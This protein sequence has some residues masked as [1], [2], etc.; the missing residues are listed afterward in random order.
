MTHGLLDC[1]LATLPQVSENED[2]EWNYEVYDADRKIFKIVALRVYEGDWD[3]REKLLEKIL[4][5]PPQAHHYISSFL[6]S[7][8]ILS[9]RSDPPE[10]KRLLLVWKEIGNQLMS[11]KTFTEFK[12]RGVRE[13]WGD[14]LFYGSSSQGIHEECF[15]PFVCGLSEFYEY[16]LRSLGQSSHSH[17]KLASIFSSKAGAKMLV[18]SLTWFLPSWEEAG[19]YYWQDVSKY[20]GFQS[21]LEEAWTNY[22]PLI[23]TNTEALKGFKILTMQLAKFQVP[24]ALEVQSQLGILK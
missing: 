6:S 12:R 18:D 9:L 2:V 16:I 19:N 20:S 14:F 17:S 7:L 8:Y 4:G 24:V 13:V 1:M 5:L 10:T 11:S 21:L 22:F 3:L 15:A 23:R